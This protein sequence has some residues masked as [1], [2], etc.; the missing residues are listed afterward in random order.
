MIARRTV[1]GSGIQ[2]VEDFGDPRQLNQVGGD[3]ERASRS[4]DQKVGLAAREGE[5]LGR[6]GILFSTLVL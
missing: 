3:V 5:G 1:G 4:E 6:E 2:R